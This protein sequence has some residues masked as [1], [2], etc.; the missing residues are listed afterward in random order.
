ME[1]DCNLKRLGQRFQIVLCVLEKSL[2]TSDSL[3]SI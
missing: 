3:V 1:M 2:K